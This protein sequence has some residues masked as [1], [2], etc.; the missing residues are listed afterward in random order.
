MDTIT[1][2]STEPSAAATDDQA[3]PEEQRARRHR[4]RLI[5][6]MVV[7]VVLVLGTVIGGALYHVPYYLLSPGSTYRTQGVIEIKGAPT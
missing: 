3:D 2:D 7:F 4:N 5:V 1:P 6:V